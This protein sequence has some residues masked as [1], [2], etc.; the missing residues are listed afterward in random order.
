MKRGEHLSPETKAKLSASHKGRTPWNKGLPMSLEQKT[1]LSAINTGKTH[2]VS[3]EARVKIAAAQM[4]NKSRLG[5]HASEETKARMSAANK[6]QIQRP[7]S[8]ETRAKESASHWKGGRKVTMRKVHAKRRLLG[9]NPLN[10]AFAGCEAHH[11][12]PQ[13]VIHI[14][15]VLHR[16]IYH[17]QYTGQ[18]MAAM[19]TLAGQY[20]TEDWT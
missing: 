11:V 4:G 15:T 12:N 14:P 5:L 16:S 13:D 8:D 1:Y 10:S 20:L 7:W 6:G 2:S 19:N 9:F 18:G 3:V 17:N